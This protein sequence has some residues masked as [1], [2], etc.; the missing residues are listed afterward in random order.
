MSS[1]FSYSSL[2]TGNRVPD[3]NLFYN[4]NYSPLF[5]SVSLLLFLFL[6]FA[7]SLPEKEKLFAV[8]YRYIS[9][10]LEWCR[11]LALQQPRQSSSRRC[12]HKER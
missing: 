2:S 7:L 11:V 9:V 1:M 6:S 10:G 3:C 12:L 8:A 5:F 4:F